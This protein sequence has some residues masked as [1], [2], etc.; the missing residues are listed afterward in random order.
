LTNAT[1]WLARAEQDLAAATLLHG[2]RLYPLSIFHLQ[3]ASEKISKAMMMEFNEFA[4]RFE[5]AE[6]ELNMRQLGHFWHGG[7]VEWTQ[8]ILESLLGYLT[9]LSPEAR[10][11]AVSVDPGIIDNLHAAIGDALSKLP[12]VETHL[13]LSAQTGQEINRR[14]SVIEENVGQSSSLLQTYE[15]VF[16]NRRPST[17]SQN[18]PETSRARFEIERI[19]VVV[20]ML[21]TFAPLYGLGLIL[22]PHESRS[23]YPSDGPSLY[24]ESSPVVVASDRILAAS[25]ACK[26]IA[27]R[28]TSLLPSS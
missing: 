1:E 16:G 10:N 7:Y 27:S 4:R 25:T 13:P 20:F 22:N 3:Q 5:L 11:F 17:G 15:Q 26:E 12:S 9:G 19:V 6:L 18:L 21:R 28:W 24:E 8:R 14:I 23:R 2:N